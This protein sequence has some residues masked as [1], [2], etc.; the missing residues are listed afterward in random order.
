[1]LR[2]F[3]A[4]ADAYDLLAETVKRVWG[5]ESLP[6]I[7]REEGGKPYFPDYPDYHFN[8]SHSGNFS[9]CAL[10]DSPVGVDLELTRPRQKDLPER[11]FTGTTLAKYRDLGGG[12]NAFYTIWTGIESIIKYTGQGLS[13]WRET[14][15]PRGC[16]LSPLD[17]MGWQGAVCSPEK[18]ESDVEIVRPEEIYERQADAK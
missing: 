18:F 5:L 16:E 10:S 11:L 4:E 1:M 15:L 17:G 12:W 7:E 8:L 14:E 3:I 6:A 2:I 13:A 9:I